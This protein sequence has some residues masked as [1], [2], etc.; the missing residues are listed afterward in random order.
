M[1]SKISS[2]YICDILEP[3]II[4]VRKVTS[5]KDVWVT[6]SLA[7]IGTH[8]AIALTGI[9]IGK[10][11]YAAYMEEGEL[12]ED[13]NTLVVDDLKSCYYF[14][15][16]EKDLSK[17]YTVKHNGTLNIGSKYLLAFTKKVLDFASNYTEPIE[18]IEIKADYD[19][20]D[21]TM[22]GGDIEIEEIELRPGVNKSEAYFNISSIHPGKSLNTFYNVRK[23][24]SVLLSQNFNGDTLVVNLI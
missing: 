8:F 11:S 2:K 6:V 3:I 16:V 19:Y 9:T 7:D 14:W 5:L 18:K 17:V 13:P 4:G 21:Y 10:A 22:Y 15:K 20:I 1:N 12:V 24:E 23:K